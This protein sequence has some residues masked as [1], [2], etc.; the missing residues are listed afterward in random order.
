M[1]DSGQYL[2]NPRRLCCFTISCQPRASD[3]KQTLEGFQTGINLTVCHSI[4][5]V[6]RNRLFIGTPLL[7]ILSTASAFVRAQSS[8]SEKS[9][10]AISTA[11][12]ATGVKA[13]G[14]IVLAIILDIKRPYHIN[15]NTANAPLIPTSI[16]LVSGPDFLLSSTAVFPRPEEIDFGEEGAKERIKVFSDRTIAYIPIAVGRGAVPGHHELKVRIGYQA[17]NDRIC[18][19]PTETTQS[20]DLNVV[21][22]RAEIQVTHP[23]LFEGLTALRDRL[24]IPFFGLDFEI[25][26]SRFWLLLIIAALGGFLLNLTPCVLPL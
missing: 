24:N 19:L 16:Q 21:P 8:A 10:L 5:R 23:D 15:A 9:V 14:Q 4:N 13:N 2:E 12:S 17:C 3:M 26:P 11:W 6:R 25:A 20:L 7:W 18:L 1:I 22:A